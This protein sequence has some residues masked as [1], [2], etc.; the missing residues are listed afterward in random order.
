MER[1]IAALSDEIADLEHGRDAA[2]G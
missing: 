1:R 2:A